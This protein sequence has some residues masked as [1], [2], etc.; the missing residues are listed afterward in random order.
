MN[1]KEWLIDARLIYQYSSLGI[2]SDYGRCG[3]KP[4]MSISAEV[5]HSVFMFVT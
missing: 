5:S 2:A 1:G 3:K 4:V